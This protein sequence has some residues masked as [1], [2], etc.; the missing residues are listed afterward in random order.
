[1]HTYFVNAGVYALSPE[2]L[3]LLAKGQA[4]D[5]PDL[6]ERTIAELGKPVVFPIREY[7]LDIGR[8]DDLAKAN[9]DYDDVFE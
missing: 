9:L 2:V 6:L 4:I 1:M 7:W 3:P 8:T 5:M